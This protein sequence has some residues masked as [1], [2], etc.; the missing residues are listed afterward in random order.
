MNCTSV[1]PAG[2]RASRRSSRV[3]L[4]GAAAAG[5]PVASAAIRIE[6]I[7]SVFM[8]WFLPVFRISAAVEL[9]RRGRRKFPRVPRE[10]GSAGDSHDDA[11]RNGECG[12]RLARLPATELREATVEF[13][14][15]GAWDSELDDRPVGRVE[16]AGL[17]RAEP[18]DELF[19]TTKSKIAVAH[20]ELA[21][22]VGWHE[23][24]CGARRRRGRRRAR[25]PLSLERVSAPLGDV[26]LGRPLAL[27]SRRGRLELA[28]DRR[29]PVLTLRRLLK[30]RIPRGGR[31]LR[32]GGRGGVG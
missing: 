17:D 2:N 3:T 21:R 16:P 32:R 15:R 7:S 31:G 6:A 19:Q 13:R 9:D 14:V 1:W 8:T 20:R 27:G 28:D 29:L 24:R 11:D 25:R 10:A 22:D 18:R 4:T 12:R 23:G 5:C 26:V 30:I